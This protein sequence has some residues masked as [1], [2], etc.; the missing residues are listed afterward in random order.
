MKGQT[1]IKNGSSAAA[2][3]A[4]GIG[5]AVTGIMTVTAEN[6][7]A[8]GKA[9]TWS[10]AVGNLTGEDDP[11]PHR[12]DRRVGPSRVLLEGQGSEASICAVRDNNPCRCRAADYVPAILRFVL[13]ALRRIGCGRPIN[14]FRR[15]RFSNSRRKGHWGDKKPQYQQS[16]LRCRQSICSD[17]VESLLEGEPCRASDRRCLFVGVPKFDQYLP[18]SL[19]LSLGQ[20]PH[21]NRDS[22][23]KARRGK[24]PDAESDPLTSSRF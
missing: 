8:W 6:I 18:G 19:M 21:F 10:K 12:V 9:L 7:A 13:E 20:I 16:L 15:H 23:A 24:V 22:F 3:L 1:Q 17:F 11:R 4:A 2:I 14:G 5:L